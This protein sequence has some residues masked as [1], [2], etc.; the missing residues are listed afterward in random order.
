MK[1]NFKSLFQTRAKPED[2][3]NYRQFSIRLSKDGTPKT[4]DSETRKSLYL[5]LINV[6]VPVACWGPSETCKLRTGN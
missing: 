4:L 2:A 3:L 5:T 6:E 1:L